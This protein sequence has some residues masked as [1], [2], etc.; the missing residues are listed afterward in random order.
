V[1]LHVWSFGG[2]PVAAAGFE[3]PGLLAV[4]HVRC[5][6]RSIDRRA[7]A[8][9]VEQSVELPLTAID[10]DFVLARIVGRVVDIRETAHGV[11]EVRIALSPETVAQDPGQLMNMLF[12]NTSLHDEVTLVDVVFPPDLVAALGGP[13]HGVDGLRRRAQ[14]GR[15]ALTCS[16]LKPQ[17]LGSDR[18]A[19]LAERFARGGVD[20]VKD[21]HG[22][23][24]QSYSP[25][26]TRVEAISRRLRDLAQA[27]GG[28]R[29]IP[30]L[31]GSLDAMRRQILLAQQE[32]VDV[33]MVAPMIAGLANVHQLVQENPGLAFVAHPT[34]AGAARVAP[35]LLIGKI[36]R[37]VGID[38][39]IFPNHGG[40]FGYSPETCRGIAAT[41]LGELNGVRP[42]MPVPAGGMSRERVAEMLDFYGPDIM[43][44]IGGA[45]LGAGARL[46][47]ATAAFV[48]D[49]QGY[50]HGRNDDG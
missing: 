1:I 10:D 36:F 3:H 30:S 17:G 20:Y 26:A 33:V 29:Y 9:A 35:P 5:D 46:I 22:L 45:L 19:D 41:A 18:L 38:A 31:S 23:A 43:L 25:F 39:V 27:D 13:R 15:R 7:S 47:E 4:Y 11:F 24:D 48:S 49:V 44:L 8:I 2:D 28:T 32:G 16:A 34:M 40:R 37:M 50:R 21:D 12:G 6:A 42:A 14:A